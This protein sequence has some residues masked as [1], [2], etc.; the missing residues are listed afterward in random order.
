[1]FK[2]KAVLKPWCSTAACY[3]AETDAN[4]KGGKRKGKEYAVFENTKIFYLV[5][6]NAS[7][8]VCLSYESAV[9]LS[10][11]LS[12]SSGIRYLRGVAERKIVSSYPGSPLCQKLAWPPEWSSSIAGCE[13]ETDTRL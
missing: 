13:T 1:M 12:V 10:V 7:S 2:I 4:K 5:F 9:V 8:N 11:I 3:R 6:A